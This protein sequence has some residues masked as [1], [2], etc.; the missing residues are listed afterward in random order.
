VIKM[1]AKIVPQPGMVLVVRTAGFEGTMIR[2][3]AAMIGESDLENH[4][5]VIDHTDNHGTCWAIE[6]RP[7]GVGWV[8]ASSYLDSPWTISNQ[9]QDLTAQQRTGI[10]TTM[11]GLL[12]VPYDWTAITED[13]IRD[14]HLPDLW[15]EKWHGV[16]PGHVVCSS[17]AVWTYKKNAA[18]YPANIDPAHVQPADWADFIVL[19][20]FQECPPVVK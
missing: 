16:A 4:V 19:N 13:G 14:L 9:G 5:A 20:G 3:G 7:G 12:G 8:D 10:C 6:G 2:F 18:K 15:G 11:R 17:A 1:K